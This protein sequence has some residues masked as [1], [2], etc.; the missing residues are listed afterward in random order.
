[1][2]IAAAIISGVI[3]TASI[4]TS[5]A[6]AKAAEK[7]AAEQQEKAMK[8]QEGEAEKDRRLKELQLKQQGFQTLAEQRMKNEQLTRQRSFNKDAMAGMRLAMQRRGQ[9]QAPRPQ[10]SPNAPQSQGL[11]TSTFG[12]GM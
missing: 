2:G 7:E 12:R 4:I 9:R 6:G 10:M 5:V 8:F 11:P 3:G 1:M